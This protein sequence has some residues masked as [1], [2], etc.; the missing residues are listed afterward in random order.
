[1][2]FCSDFLSFSFFLFP[3]FFNKIFFKIGPYTFSI[4]DT[5]EFSDYISG[6]VATQVKTQKDFT[7]VSYLFSISIQIRIEWTSSNKFF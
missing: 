5:S 6:G 1:M 3:F 4:G 2:R 7:F